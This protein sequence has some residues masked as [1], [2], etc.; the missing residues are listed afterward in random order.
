MSDTGAGE[1]SAAGYGFGAG[2]NVNLPGLTAAS[3]QIDSLNSSLRGLNDSLSALSSKSSTL[4]SSLTSM[5]TSI[6]QAAAKT[7]AT[8]ASMSSAM[9]SAGAMGG[10]SSATA[11][12]FGSPGAYLPSSSGRSSGLSFTQ[13]LGTDGTFL[14]SM[15]LFPLRFMQDRINTNR[16]FALS[17]SNMLGGQQFATGMNTQDYMKNLAGMPGNIQGSG[18]DVM[19]MMAIARQAGGMLNFGANGVDMSRSGPRAAGLFSGVQ[20]AQMMNPGDSVGQIAGTIGGFASNTGAQ[21]QAQ[22]MTGGAFGMIKPGGGQKSLQEWAESVLRWL[23]GLRG[24][25]DRGKPF[26]YGNLMAQY[27]PGSNIDAWFNANGVP[28]GMKDYWWTYVLGKTQG[29]NANTQ[30]NFTIT[31]QSQNLSQLRLSSQTSLTSTEFGLAGSLGGTYG[32]REQ[33]NKWFNELMGSMMQQLL[34]QQLSGGILSAAQ[35]MPDSIEDLIMSLLNK[36]GPLG[37]GVGAAIGYGPGIYNTIKDKITGDVGDIGDAGYGTNGATTTAGLNPDMRKRVNAMMRANPNLQVNSG[38]RDLDTQQKLKG[39]GGNRV[40]GKASAHTAGRA[41]DLG[42]RS[43]YGWL[44][45]N[46]GKFGLKSGVGAGEPWHV[47]WP[48]DIGDTGVGSGGGGGSSGSGAS[49]NTGYSSIMSL[50]TGAG[51]FDSGSGFLQMLD[52]LFKIISG[53]G[54]ASDMVGLMGTSVPLLLSKLL[55][56]FGSS[57]GGNTDMLNFVPDLYEQLRTTSEETLRK[58]TYGGIPAEPKDG[59][60][61]L[62]APFGSTAGNDSNITYGTLQGSVGAGVGPAAFTG[63]VG[64]LQRA[65]AAVQVAFNAGFRGHDLWEIV[66]IGGR[67]SGGWRP[68]AVNPNTADRGLFQINMAG[69]AK[70]MKAMGYSEQDLLDPA[71]NALIAH[72]L[73]E[74]S[75]EAWW[76]WGLNS[77]GVWDRNGD[78]L[79]RTSQYQPTVTQAIS[80]LGVGDM[81][82]GGGGGGYS[83]T[84]VHN[85]KPT[86]NLQMTG[87]GQGQGIDLRRTVSTLADALEGEMNKRMVRTS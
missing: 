3:G 45:A 71:K 56:F 8:I 6:E 1:A 36:S 50:L 53:Q 76:P 65:K 9:G 64:S 80:D 60:F 84:T 73:W 5:L 31:P 74:E 43:Q 37:A 82:Y 62:G 44:V 46:A 69:N 77:A 42:P 41:V 66:S 18:A 35:F 2:V 78:P 70:T 83:R 63:P 23:E 55:G 14:N 10:G 38:L 20:Q 25:S 17:A 75:G 34:P 33:S 12:S 57:T 85:W 68:D 39:R 13:A 11:A 27:F 67:E 7:T 86:I 26:D 40:S 4:T 51:G 54:S 47:G 30:D 81:D 29:K 19:S 16:E 24:G 52:P 22:M 49:P 21:Q 87:G 32:N 72:R 15:A 61:N 58:T 28:Q 59:G 79:A 48:G